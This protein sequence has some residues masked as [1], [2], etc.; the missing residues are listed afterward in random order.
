MHRF[1]GNVRRR[2]T[3]A[4]AFALALS[5]GL[6][7]CKLFEGDSP[8]EADPDITLAGTC[9][10]AAGRQI[11]CEDRSR[12]EPADRIRSITFTVLDD[13]GLTVESRTASPD[14][15]SPRPV[16]FSGL[17]PGTYAVEHVVEGRPGG[18]ARTI[19]RNNLTVF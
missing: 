8:T 12:T 7:G 6:A 19:Y 10:A 18:E 14:Q 17:A 2:G 1:T 4:L 11:V 5:L 9:R 3:A 15:R 16:I 13:D